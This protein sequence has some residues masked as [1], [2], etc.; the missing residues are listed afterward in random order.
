MNTIDFFKLQAKN[1]FRDFKTQTTQFDAESGNDFYEYTPKY[2]DVL[3]LILDDY[4][5]D[6]DNFTLMNAQHLIARLVGFYKWTDMVK[7][8]DAELKLAKLL[9]DNLHKISA[10]EWTW[11]VRGV[12]E[13]NKLILDADFKL[14]IFVQVFANVDGHKSDFM[15]YRLIA[16]KEQEIDIEVAD[17]E[18]VKPVKKKRDVQIK[19]LP[20]S[21]KD[22]KKFI[23][24]ANEVFETVMWRMEP[25]HPELTRKLWD[26]EFYID[27]VLLPELNLPIG[28]EYAL[29]LIDAFLF[30]YVL[31]LAVKADETA[32][33]LN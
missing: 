29:S 17:V 6:E 30:H 19:T 21:D 1:L 20:L 4:I 25:D 12:E 2:F 7:A 9:F 28:R 16:T 24:T 13:D 26:A 33:T 11:Y 32:E 8:S 3:G 31:E 10:E 15:D 14:E 27:K 23:K 5:T 22:R 18:A